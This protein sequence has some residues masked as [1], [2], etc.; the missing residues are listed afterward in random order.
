LTEGGAVK[1]L[2]RAGPHAGAGKG[3]G[4]GQGMTVILGVDSGGTKTLA[5]LARPDGRVT[6][7]VRAAS[8]DP[9]AV[10]DWAERLRALVAGLDLGPKDLAAAA[11]GLSYHGEIDALSA[12]QDRLVAGILPGRV[13]VDNDVRIAFDGA[14]AGGAGGLILAGTGSMAWASLG[15]P[16]DPHTRSGGWGD[17]FG[18]EGSAY[19]IGREA[20]AD[21]AREIDGRLPASGFSAQ[22]LAALGV[23]PDGLLAWC[24]AQDQRRSAIADL[25]RQVA[26]LAAAGDGVALRILERA[27]DELAAALR[28]AWVRAA[29]T[30][31]LV[32]SYAGGVT[33]NPVVLARIA[34][35][36]GCAPVPCRLPPVGGALLRAARLAG[37]PV[38]EAWVAEV[39][40]SLAEA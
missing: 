29:G 1:K 12:E 16:G 33:T 7:L 3:Q 5:A 34:A 28:A 4:E 2:R 31:P 19:W 14:F 11:L 20:L 25:A 30:R 10:P 22:V 26:D 18:D 38:T 21:T 39:A 6:R 17:I 35:R 36:V 13:V 23:G 32:W 15:G 40:R 37:W 24:Y 27:G 9:V 8:L